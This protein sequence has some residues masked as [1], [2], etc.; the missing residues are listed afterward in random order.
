[1]KQTIVAVTML[2]GCIGLAGLAK[3]DT[4]NDRYSVA[5]ASP[6]D[7]APGSTSTYNVSVTND[8][9]SGPSHFVRQVIVTVPTGFT[10]ITS[11]GASSPVTP[12]PGWNLQSISGQTI[13]VVTMSSTDTSITAGKSVTIRITAQAPAMSGGCSATQSYSWQLSVNQDING[14]VGNTYGLRLGSVTPMIV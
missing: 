10:L 9:K 5:G 2:L 14:G 11:P 13:T 4:V 3:G 6:S 8:L 1:M 7:V 12:P